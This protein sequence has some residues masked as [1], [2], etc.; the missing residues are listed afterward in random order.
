M[1]WNK[2]LAVSTEKIIGFNFFT[3]RKSFFV[4]EEKKVAVICNINKFKSTKAGIYE[5][6]YIVG[7]N[8]YLKEMD[9]G[10][11]VNH[12]DYHAY[13]PCPLVCSSYVPSLVPSLGDKQGWELQNSPLGDEGTGALQSVEDLG[14]KYRAGRPL[15]PTQKFQDMQWPTVRGRGNRG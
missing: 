8:G 12:K 10:E 3:T 13:R 6:A 15:K 4:E 5:T 1:F 9:L 14:L 11:A 7:E 2:F